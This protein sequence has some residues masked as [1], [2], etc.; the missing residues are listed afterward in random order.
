[1]NESADTSG[2]GPQPKTKPKPIRDRDGLHKR[3]GI[4]HYKLLIDGQW[5]ERSTGT[6]DY[7]EAR[8]IHR[9]TL[10]A[11]TEGK[12]PSDM[13]KAK[14]AVAAEHWLEERVK[15]VAAKTLKIDKERLKP[16]GRALGGKRLCEISAD[17]IRAYQL[18]RCEEVGNRTVNLETKV[19]RGIMKR[20]RTWAKVAD[21]YRPLKESR[22]G[23]GRALSDEQERHL[24]VL[25]ASRPGWET[26]YLAALLAANT[27]TRGVEIRHLL[28]SDVDMEAG[29]IQI[30][31]SKTEAGHREVPLNPAA[32]WAV[33]RLLERAKAVQAAEPH[34]HLFPACEHGNIDPE[35][36]QA[37]WRTAWRALTTAAGLKGLRFH[38][39]RH[40][41]ITKLAEAGVPEHTM[42]AIA[43]HVSPQMTRHYSHVRQ[44]STRKA[45]E[46]IACFHPNQPATEAGD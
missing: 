12:L 23:P 42:M 30:R 22:R 6:R 16:L 27:A 33:S 44:G 43:G 10:Q 9:E 25:A 32:A 19:L 2:Y 11:Q 24:F 13:G 26:A 34:H 28:V 39:L 4:W 38:D 18:R 17:D 29:V 45:V 1:M 3:R 46:A 41:A 8:T 35:V 37:T 40:H 15:L 5:R 36:P 31:R 7:R 21:E 20:Y 14:L